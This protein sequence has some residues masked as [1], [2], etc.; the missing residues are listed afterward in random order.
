VIQHCKNTYSTRIKQ[1]GQMFPLF[2]ECKTKSREI[3]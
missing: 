3:Y 1:Y 2:N